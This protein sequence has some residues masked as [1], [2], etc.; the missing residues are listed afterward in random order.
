MSAPAPASDEKKS[1]GQKVHQGVM[2]GT[3]GLLI[4][5][6]LNW[7]AIAAG[8]GDLVD[9]LLKKSPKVSRAVKG[10]VGVSALYV[11]IG[12]LHAV[13]YKKKKDAAATPSA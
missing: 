6:G 11:L 10:L 4:L 7:G 9:K 2:V 8:K 1:L 13:Y 3:S 5:G 12:I